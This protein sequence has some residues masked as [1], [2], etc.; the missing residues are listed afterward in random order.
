MGQAFQAHSDFCFKINTLT[1]LKGH[2]LNFIKL[3]MI[4][5]IIVKHFVHNII[6]FSA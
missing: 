2:C 5:S 1:L 6:T 3:N 4:V